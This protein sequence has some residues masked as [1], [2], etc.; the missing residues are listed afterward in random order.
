LEFDPEN[1]AIY[2]QIIAPYYIKQNSTQYQYFVE[3]LMNDWSGW[4]KEQ[5]INLIVKSGNYTLHVRA[6]DIWG[7]KSEIKSLKFRIKP[8]FTE[9]VWFYIGIAVVMI[10]VFVFIS[11]IREKKLLHDKKILEQKVQERTIE[12]QEKAEEIESQRDEIMEQR[13]EILRQKE[14]ITDSINYAKR[15]Q[16]AVLPLR[17]HFD[18][19]FSDHFIL[20]NPAI[21]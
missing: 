2:V 13:D 15:I 1:K 12:I 18:K 16:N 10:L 7:N 14:E 8:P 21:L 19:A 5:N 20:F 17:D 9:S 6:K 4:S 11:K 3:G